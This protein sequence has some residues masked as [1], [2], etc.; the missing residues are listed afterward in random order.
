MPRS[1]RSVSVM[2]ERIQSPWTQ[3]FGRRDLDEDPPRLDALPFAFPVAVAFFARSKAAIFS[4]TIVAGEAREGWIS[5]GESRRSGRRQRGRREEWEGTVQKPSP[6]ALYKDASEWLTSRP[7]RSCHIPKQSRTH[8]TWRKR[9]H[10]NRGV[11]A[12]S[13]PSTAVRPA[14]RASQNSDPTKSVDGRSICQMIDFL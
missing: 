14:S 3:P 8:D 6:D 4:F 7:G 1:L 13:H 5:R 9:R 2:V 10:G 12:L 11:H